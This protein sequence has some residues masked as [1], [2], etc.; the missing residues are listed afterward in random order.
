VKAHQQNQDEV[1]PA[2]KVKVGDVVEINGS[3]IHADEVR[4]RKDGKIKLTTVPLNG[5]RVRSVL[6]GS[7]TDV[8]L[9][10]R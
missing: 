10:R 8:R 3:R 4:V 6:L 2:A 1:I 9:V 7:K 5:G